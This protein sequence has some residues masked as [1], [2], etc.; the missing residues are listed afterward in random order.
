M[1]II[2][3]N[4]I[5]FKGFFA[6]NLFG[7]V[8]A[9]KD[10]YLRKSQKSIG[11][12]KRH[13]AI[14]TAQ[15]KELLYIGFYI[16]YFLEWIVRLVQDYKNAYYNISFEVEAYTYEDYPGYLDERKHYAQWKI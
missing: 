1:K 2:L 7:F 16:L 5:P 12:M 10:V 15:M 8:F 3:N 13:E 14:H 11:R 4:I 6:I 9:R